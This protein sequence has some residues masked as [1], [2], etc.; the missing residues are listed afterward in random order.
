[1]KFKG[2]H[3]KNDFC[4]NLTADGEF[5]LHSSTFEFEN[6]EIKAELVVS[7]KNTSLFAMDEDLFPDPP[8][9]DR[10]YQLELKKYW[11]KR[12]NDANSYMWVLCDEIAKKVGGNV[13]K[14]EIYRK[15]V[16]EVGV[17]EVVPLK[18]EALPR[19]IST[20]R[21]NGVGWL[22]ESLGKSKLPGYVNLVCYYG[23][24]TYDSKEM[25]RL[26]DY[27]VEEAKNLGIETMTPAELDALKKSWEV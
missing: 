11:K 23:S 5:S 8:I 27:I 20:W 2:K 25:S 26:I 10:I 13:T 24:S 15:A 9:T 21:K 14:E 16:R 7:V 3:L 6:G 12:S 17:F 4:Y 22:C 18:K 19:F 1:M